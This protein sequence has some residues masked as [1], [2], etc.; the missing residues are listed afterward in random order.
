MVSLMNANHDRLLCLSEQL[1]VLVPGNNASGHK[2]F[3]FTPL[4]CWESQAIG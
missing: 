4:K 1:Y 3:G 2:Y